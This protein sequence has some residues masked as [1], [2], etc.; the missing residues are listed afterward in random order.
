[1]ARIQP[2]IIH[3]NRDT[4]VSVSWNGLGFHTGTCTVTGNY[5]LTFTGTHGFVAGDVGQAAYFTPSGGTAGLYAIATVPSGT[6]LTAVAVGF[7]AANTGSV[8]CT[9]GDIGGAYSQEDGSLDRTLQVHGTF[10]SSGNLGFFGSN[11][12]INWYVSSDNTGTQLNVTSVKVRNVYDGPLYYCPM[13]TAGDAT[14]NLNAIMVFRTQ[15]P[16]ADE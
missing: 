7:S 1:M 6:S 2:S 12:A 5:L 11:D 9:V 4:C 13:I 16:R 3:I 10:G 15:L 8:A 14:T